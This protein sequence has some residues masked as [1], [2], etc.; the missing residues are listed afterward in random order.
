MFKILHDW[1]FPYYVA[2]ECYPF[3]TK[4]KWSQR[5]ITKVLRISNLAARL[6]DYYNCETAAIT[7]QAS[8]A[9]HV[10]NLYSMTGKMQTKLHWKFMSP[11]QTPRRN[12]PSPNCPDAELAAPSCPRPPTQSCPWVGLGWV[13][14]GQDF[15]F[16]VGWA[17]LGP[18]QQKY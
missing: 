2:N 16:L 17:G 6:Y 13:G 12:V 8:T 11:S 5:R 15:Q 18:L 9:R 1:I 10:T 7:P 3:C 4:N 14:L